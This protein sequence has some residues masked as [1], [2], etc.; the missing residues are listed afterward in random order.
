LLDAGPFR[1]MNFSLNEL[2]RVVGD[3]PAH[4]TDLKAGVAAGFSI[5][6]RQ[7]L[8]SPITLTHD[9]NQSL[10]C[11]S[12]GTTGQPKTVKR[13]PE[14]WIKSFEVTQRAYAISSIDTYAT[15]GIIGHSLT[16]FATLE[17][18]HIGTDIC[19]LENI[20]PSHQIKSIDANK[21]TVIYATPSQLTLLVS[22]ARNAKNPEIRSVRHLFSGG[23]KLSRPLRDDLAKL[24]PV[25]RILEFF[26]AS[27]TSFISISD[28]QTPEGSVG[29]PY[30]NVSIRI[31]DGQH[32]KLLKPDEIWV[33]SPYLFDAYTTGQSADTRWDGA[34][35][36]I[37]EMGALDGQGY[38][39]LSGRKNRMV[40]IADNNV[41]P[42][43][44]ERTVLMLDGI[45]A[46]A[47]LSQP[48]RLRGNKLVC[49]VQS[50]SGTI[51]MPQLRQHCRAKIDIHSVPK[52]FVFLDSMPC[53]AAGK[54][55]LGK[56]RKMLDEGL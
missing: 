43:E 28:E 7:H 30:P 6:A 22:G 11:E 48:D 5:H 3:C 29:R 16:L 47:V 53:L 17:A 52:E 54:P 49:F 37:G 55:D 32:P 13:R 27:E 50:S 18:F 15:L 21:V 33:K 14:S 41:F 1:K 38:L 9:E 44:I 31:G 45:D 42:E 24:F 26:G 46:C 51:T 19:P 2:S 34:Y 10:M 35:L 56:L 12:S 8:S 23:G 4:L 39:F 36:S 40:T 25:A 20:S